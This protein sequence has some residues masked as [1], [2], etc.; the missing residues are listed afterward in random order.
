METANYRISKSA[1]LKGHEHPV[2]D[3]INKRIDMMTNLNQDTAED[4][5]VAN[6]GIGGHYDPHFDFAVRFLLILNNYRHWWA[7]RTSSG[8]LYCKYILI[9]FENNVSFQRGE[10]DPYRAGTGKIKL[11]FVR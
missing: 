11:K 4:L 8:F 7:L 1:W 6:Y 9:Q 5:Q 3:R 10:I 2:I